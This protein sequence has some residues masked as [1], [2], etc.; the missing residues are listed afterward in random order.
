MEFFKHLCIHGVLDPI[1]RHPCEPKAATGTVTVPTNGPKRGKP[2]LDME[3]SRKDLETVRAIFPHPCLVDLAPWESVS[4]SGPFY[5]LAL[6]LEGEAAQVK[7][8]DLI[9]AGAL[10]ETPSGWDTSEPQDV[11]QNLERWRDIVG[12]KFTPDPMRSYLIDRRP[13]DVPPFRHVESHNSPEMERNAE[14]V[15]H[16]GQTRRGS[17]LESLANIAV[18][19]SINYVA[20][21]LIFPLFGWNLSTRENL[22]LGVIY[23][24]ISLARS[25]TLRRIFNRGGLRK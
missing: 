15:P 20:N 23:T 6:V 18:G 2:F 7:D 21:M 16:K 14:S 13:L 3:G 4:F 10:V 12:Q 22:T 24:A 19:Y 11:L 5:S 17:L 1:F 9:M 8:A 25:Y